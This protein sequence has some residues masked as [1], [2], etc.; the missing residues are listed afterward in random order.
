MGSFNRSNRFVL[1]TVSLNTGIQIH[2][3]PSEYTLMGARHSVNE[4]VIPVYSRL[5]QY[6]FVFFILHVIFLFYIREY[7][8]AIYT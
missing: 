2:R 8:E 4:E 7:N 3:N 5:F 1:F 6:F